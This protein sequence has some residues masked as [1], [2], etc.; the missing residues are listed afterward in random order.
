MDTR[1]IQG[2]H[3]EMGSIPRP[4]PRHSTHKIT[5]TAQRLSLGNLCIRDSATASNI[6]WRE[7]TPAKI[8][9][10]YKM[11]A[12]SWPMG[13]SCKMVGRVTNSRLGPAPTSS[14]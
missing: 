11:T 2:P 6:F 5:S 10:T 4:K 7:L 13:M 12:K 1:S 9:A 14:P 8:M 3:L